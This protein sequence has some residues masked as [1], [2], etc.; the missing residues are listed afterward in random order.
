M[1]RAPGGGTRFEDFTDGDASDSIA[2]NGTDSVADAP[3]APTA[4]VT[5][6]TGGATGGDTN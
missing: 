5:Q 6:P 4:D 2:A 3:S 1:V